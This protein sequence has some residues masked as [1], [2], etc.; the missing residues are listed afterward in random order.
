MVRSI[1]SILSGSNL[2]KRSY[3]LFLSPALWTFT[4][5]NDLR[6]C[7]SAL[8]VMAERTPVVKKYRDALETVIGATMEFLARLPALSNPTPELNLSSPMMA[9][10]TPQQKGLNGNDGVGVGNL[11]P[12]VAGAAQESYVRGSPRG[13][14]GNENP[15]A[16]A[17]GNAEFLFDPVSGAGAG[18]DHDGFSYMPET[19]HS[20]GAVG[21]WEGRHG[22]MGQ[23]DAEWLLSLCEGDGFSLQMLNEMM[24]FEPS[25]G[26]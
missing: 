1:P 12:G 5:S 14:V 16:K 22:E 8:F 20:P 2:T 10:R 15:S 23:M 26:A 21:R 11:S 3:C 6:A 17:Q 18:G 24:R 7:S 9:A 25:L 4:V 19:N 13:D